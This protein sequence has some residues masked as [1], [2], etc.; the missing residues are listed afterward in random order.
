MDA[1]ESGELEEFLEMH[2]EKHIDTFI[3]KPI[4]YKRYIDDIFG[5]WSSDLNDLNNLNS[6]HQNINITF[7][8]DSN[9]IHF[10]DLSIFK[11]IDFYTTQVLS[12]KP[13]IKNTHIGHL[14]HNNSLHS[15]SLKLSVIKAQFLRLARKCT[16]KVL[17][18]ILQFLVYVKF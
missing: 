11:N 1:E 18:L 3:K 7:E 13:Y 4:I 12:F 17:I 16:F 2:L 8:F 6:I 14:L 15:K 9:C 5:I 10:L